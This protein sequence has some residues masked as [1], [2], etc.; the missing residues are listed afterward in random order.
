[1]VSGRETRYLETQL[2]VSGYRADPIPGQSGPLEGQGP[3]EQAQR[4]T[5]AWK[6]VYLCGGE[7]RGYLHSLHEPGR[8]KGGCTALWDWAHKAL[9]G[10]L[11]GQPRWLMVLSYLVPRTS[12]AQCGV[13]LS[14]RSGARRGVT[15]KWRCEMGGGS[16]ESPVVWGGNREFLGT[17]CTLHSVLL[18]NWK[19]SK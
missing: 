18:K 3:C 12:G 16:R 10:A 17:P 14:L 15:L 11:P 1:M 2:W 19:C 6:W 5:W 13:V 4:K 9:G 7:G 8:F